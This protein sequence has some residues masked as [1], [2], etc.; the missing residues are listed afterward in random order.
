MRVLFV[1]SEAAPFSKTGGLGDVCGALPAALGELGLEVR[2]LTPLYSSVQ[3][4]GLRRAGVSVPL[5][6]PFGRVTAELWTSEARRRTRFEFVDIPGLFDRPKLYG[7]PDDARRFAAFS[8]AALS[9]TQLTG[10]SPHIVQLNDWPTGLAAL[11]RSTSYA[12]TS[13]GR[14]VCVFGLHNLAYQGNFPKSEMD[15]LGI[16][17]RR[18]TTDGVEFYDRLSFL[19]AG[20]VYSDALI[21]VSPT[22]AEEILTPEGGFGLDGV[23]RERRGVL[24]GI[25]NGVDTDEWN[26]SADELLPAQFSWTDFSGRS[27]C[28]A[29]VLERFRISAPSDGWPIFGAVGR[30]VDQKG[31]DLMQEAVPKF[32]EQGARMVVV[33]SG[34]AELEGRWRE[35]A[36]HFPGRLGVHLGFDNELAHLVEAGADFFVMP[37]RFEPC[38][39][40]QMYSLMYGAVPIVRSVGG[41]KD[42]VVDASRADG[43]GI[44]FEEAT[45]DALVAALSR[46]VELHRQPERI[47]SL[48]ARGMA[49]DFSWKTAARKYAAVYEQLLR[50]GP[51]LARYD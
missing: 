1:A 48:R 46:A 13:V 9:L 3:R 16:P 26:S 14:A 25:L 47:A 40:N 24:H 35:L 18:F 6:F 10:F 22:Y 8:L 36:Q 17:W 28:R 45:V 23:L 29:S 51:P 42:T 4:T 49:R 43:N 44:V 41:L 32:L 15:A 30:M 27:V 12:R 34:D 19:K 2:V 50:D 21:T 20:L 31:T 7:A 11:A 37:S 5:E 33:G 39:L 38:G